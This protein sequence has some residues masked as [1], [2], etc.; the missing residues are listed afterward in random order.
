MKK[1]L[2]SSTII[3]VLAF[4][5]ILTLSNKEV[6]STATLPHLVE[7][8]RIPSELTFAGE[9]VPLEAF[10][11]KE[12]ME[13]ELLSNTYFHSQ[14]IYYIKLANRYLPIIEKILAKHGVPDDFK[15]LSIAES[16]LQNVVSSKKAAGFW[17]FLAPTAK[18]YGL[19]I[20][21]YVDER[22]HLEKAT[23]ASCKYLIEAKNKLGSWTLA[24][25]SYNA[26]MARIKR[27]MEYQKADNYY[28][29]FLTTETARYVF[30]I[31]ALKQVISQPNRYGF[32]IAQED[33]YQ[34]IPYET[35]SVDTSILDLAIFAQQHNTS[36]KTLKLLNPWLREPE[37]RNLSGK[38][39]LI[40]IPK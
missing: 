2:F 27:F 20:N 15:Y 10:D 14:T 28:D 1:I 12:R 25:A 5:F 38:T 8:Y 39:Y 13:K 3:I 16:G 4:G 32:H 9:K 31:I 37:L 24:A 7:P 11:V 18:S 29:L 26:G 33:L 19:E 34:P 17:Q 6:E 35:V 40:Q 23:E 36:Y 30:R 22:Y 21:D